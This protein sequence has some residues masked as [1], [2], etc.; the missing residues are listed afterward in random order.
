MCSVMIVVHR[1]SVGSCKLGYCLGVLLLFAQLLLMLGFVQPVQFGN[2]SCL[3]SADQQG[4]WSDSSEEAV[5]KQPCLWW[6]SAAMTLFLPPPQYKTFKFNAAP[7]PEF[8]THHKWNTPAEEE[9]YSEASDMTWN[10]HWCG[11]WSSKHWTS[12]C[13]VH[14]VHIFANYFL[15]MFLFSFLSYFVS[16]LNWGPKIALIQIFHTLVTFPFSSPIL[17]P[18]TF[19]H[20]YKMDQS[21]FKKNTIIK[22]NMQWI[23]IIIAEKFVRQ[24]LYTT[25]NYWRKDPAWVQFVHFVSS[26][27]CKS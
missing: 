18:L 3:V 25:G 21:D 19:E 16:W 23:M 1:W 5:I 13:W 9:K 22:N 8:F 10:V 2:F 14:V 4:V 27:L 15:I 26:Q 7:T 11:L 12:L 17:G 20:R 6:T 24:L